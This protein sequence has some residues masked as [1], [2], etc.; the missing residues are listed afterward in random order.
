M[1]P[2]HRPSPTGKAKERYAV[3]ISTDK[4]VEGG[5]DDRRVTKATKT[6]RGNPKGLK[7]TLG[8]P[9]GFMAFPY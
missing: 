5:R 6:A 7:G 1:S 2:K 8:A 9:V 3:A 4:A